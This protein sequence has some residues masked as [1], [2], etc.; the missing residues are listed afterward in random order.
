MNAAA[1][2]LG[3]AVVL[4]TAVVA[5]GRCA[6]DDCGVICQRQRGV[7]RPRTGCS[8]P[9]LASLRWEAAVSTFEGQCDVAFTYCE[10]SRPT[11]RHSPRDCGSQLSSVQIGDAV[12]ALE[13]TDDAVSAVCRLNGKV[14]DYEFSKQPA[15]SLACAAP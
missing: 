14:C 4:I 12:C 10:G 3:T 5:V 15:P 11:T 13:V 2:G 9:S 6:I 1:K 8:D 7:W